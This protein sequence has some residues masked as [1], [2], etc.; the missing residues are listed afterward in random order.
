MTTTTFKPIKI[1]EQ[2]APA[3][4]AALKTV[5]G[6]AI[7]N[8]YTEFCE[9]EALA[10]V[11]EKAL[12]AL[13]LPKAQRKGAIWCETSGSRVSNAYA[14][15]CRTRAATSIR[16]ER[17]HGGWWLVSATKATVYQEGGG[18]GR[19]TLT[20]AQADEAHRRFA[21]GFSVAAE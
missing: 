1:S 17:R 3:I 2:Y 9:I 14:A 18:K 6:R 19:L 7:D 5:N 16:I 15:K 12:E 11:A 4:A 13:D 10:A 20:K 8:A 21:Q